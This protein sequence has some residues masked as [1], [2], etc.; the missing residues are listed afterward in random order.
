MNGVDALSSAIRAGEIRMDAAAANIA[1]LGVGGDA[2]FQARLATSACY[3][4]M[5]AS[6]AA[7]LSD[8]QKKTLRFDEQQGFL[9]RSQL[10]PAPSADLDKRMQDVWTEVLQA[11]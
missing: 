5:P 8:E 2:P 9:A 1:R 6:K 11:K 3:W 10:Y 4:G 7:A